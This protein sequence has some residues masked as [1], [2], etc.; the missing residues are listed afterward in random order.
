MLP[1]KGLYEVAIRV[2]DLARAE[3][4]YKDVL[5]LKEGLRDDRRNWL[6]LYAGGDA[7]M[8]VLQEDKG[9]WPTQHFAFT[10]A[11]ADIKQAA[12]MLKE[13]GV[14]VSEPVFHEWMNSVSVYFA[15]PDGHA[16][17][18]LALSSS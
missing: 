10:V 9:E 5:G 4:F 15:D 12:L 16:L 8:I 6:F 13:K 14:S 2:K 11:E 1:I 7:G 18:L 17:E 3:A